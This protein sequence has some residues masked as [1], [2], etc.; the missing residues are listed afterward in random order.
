[1]SLSEAALEQRLMHCAYEARCY[2]IIQTLIDPRRSALYAHQW[3]LRAYAQGPVQSRAA[4]PKVA[5]GRQLSR[6]PSEVNSAMKARRLM[7]DM[8]GRRSRRG[9]LSTAVAALLLSGRA[10]PLF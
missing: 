8:G 10:Q 1:M 3:T 5:N 9:T 2:F 7:R 6:H 4:L